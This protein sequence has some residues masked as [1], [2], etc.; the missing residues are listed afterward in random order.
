MPTPN[1]PRYVM[2][3]SGSYSNYGVNAVMLWVSEKTPDE[4]VAEFEAETLPKKRSTWSLA[5]FLAVKGYA[6]DINGQ[7]I[8]ESERW[9]GRKDETYFNVGAVVP[10]AV[11]EEGIAK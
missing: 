1:E 2:L 5:A 10:R 9:T 11:I 6:K 8:H 4:V 7:E 3:T